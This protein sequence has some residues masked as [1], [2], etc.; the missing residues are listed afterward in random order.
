M[1][2]IKKTLQ[3]E[4]AKGWCLLQ[5]ESKVWIEDIADEETSAVSSVERSE[6][7]LNKGCKL[8]EIDILTLKENGIITVRVS[9][10]PLKGNKQEHM[11]LWETSL[12]IRS[13]NGEKKKTYI[14]TAESP[15]AAETFISDYLEINVEC[16]FEAVKVSKLEYNKVIKMYDTEREEY[17]ADGSHWIRWYKS[18][19][20]AMIEGDDDT[21]TGSKGQIEGLPANP[22]FIR[23]ERYRKLK[24]SI[25]ENPDMLSLR[26]LLVFE[27]N[28]K[29]IIIGGNMR[30][31]AMKELGY[32]ETPCK[33]IPP[34]TP[35]E[36]LK[37]YTIK[38]NAGFG[39]WDFDLLANEWNP[40]DL[41]RWCVDIPN[42]DI[43]IEDD[44]Q[45]DNFNVDDNLPKKAKS[46]TGD[47]YQLGKHRLI[48]GDSTD[49]LFMSKL[50]DDKTADLLITDPPYNVNYEEKENNLTK[51]R[52]NNRVSKN[53]NTE[54]KN[55]NLTNAGFYDFLLKAFLSAFDRTKQGGSFYVFY[56]SSETLNFRNA[57]SQA[58]F[59]IKQELIWNKNHFV[60]SRQDYQWKHEPILYGWK[61]GAPHYFTKDRSLATVIEDK[62]DIDK[63]SKSELKNMVK[64]LLQG[65]IPTTVIN[66]DKPLR[67]TDHPTMKP[68]K[69][70]GRLIKNSSR[71]GDIVLDMFGGSGSTLMAAEQLERT[72]YMVELDPCYCDV[73]V[74]RW[75]E[76]TGQTAKFEGN[77]FVS[78]NTDTNCK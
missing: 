76:F 29:Y 40:E 15:T 12:K 32:A 16:T 21:E 7:V 56:A 8:T 6:V 51:Y 20:F 49:P 35:V 10:I 70:I 63:L 2:I 23:D 11:N 62:P 58:G 43:D 73:I 24:E 22:R 68:L 69:L 74:K 13:K 53:G 37:A 18:Q 47:I 26:E 61:E 34:E 66:E 45:E 54:I 25:Q 59:T 1:E 60:L 38:D 55:D 41:Q 27:H 67:N 19:I 14:V 4:E 31:R 57:I 72:C 75:E 39:E 52:P 64:E 5:N 3:I 42:V 9:N 71:R 48:C 50:I 36:A 78:N 17:E 30:Y 65:N 28:G 33:V 44:A 46:K 77:I